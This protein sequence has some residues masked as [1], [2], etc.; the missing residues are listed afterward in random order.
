MGDGLSNMSLDEI[1]DRTLQQVSSNEEKSRRAYALRRHK[2]YRDGGREFLIEAL[3][4]EF[5][6]NSIDEFRLC[7]FNF[8][9]KIVQKKQ[10]YKSPPIRTTALDSDQALVDFYTSEL[11]VDVM[12][13]KA[14]EYYNL[15]SNT[16]LYVYPKDDFLSFKVVPPHL[17]S[18]IP[19]DVDRTKVLVWIFN[20]FAQEA[21][22][23]AQ[24]DLM[25]ATG[26]SGFERNRRGVNKAVDSGEIVVDEG[27]RFI[28]WSDDAQA[29]IT[30][31]GGLVWLDPEKGEEQFINPIGVAPVVHLQKDT[32]NE[33]WAQQGEDAADISLLLQRMWTDLATIIKHQG[34]GQMVVISEE[35]PKKLT[36]G[37]NKTLWLRRFE[38]KEPP[39]V[40]YITSDSRIS[41]IKETLRDMLF[42]LLTT[43]DI[44]PSS[45]GKAD[46]GS[47]FNSGIQALLE[48]SDAIEA[49][50]M[51]QPAHRDAEKDLWNVIALWHNWMYD[52][53]LLREDARS[54]GRF[55]NDFEMNVSYPEMKPIETDIDRLGFI[56]KSRD[57]KLITKADALKKLYPQLTDEEI[58]LKLRELDEEL[59]AVRDQFGIT[60]MIQARQDQAQDGS[61]VNGQEGEVPV[62]SDQGDQVQESGSQGTNA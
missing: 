55:S 9:K 35:P 14:N 1:I 48:M 39:S 52:T 58:D 59:Q 42:L 16:A 47:A 29:T 40:Q 22:V 7:P 15:H 20:N 12:M 32:D 45:V 38:G 41:E 24:T 30:D 26:V 53:G 43:N 5:E 60:S 33:A 46:G 11:A 21:D 49:M 62:Q 51:D 57:L 50:K 4:A 25:P 13:R 19:H 36:I 61:N 6:V 44:N 18:I 27:H 37:I 10:L 56:E 3:K 54:L 28:I 17:Y 2:I 34:F 23:I 8:L 31:K